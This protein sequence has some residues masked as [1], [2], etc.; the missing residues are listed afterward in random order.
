MATATGFPQARAP[1]EIINRHLNNFFRTPEELP[2]TWPFQLKLLVQQYNLTHHESLG[3]SPAALL[4]GRQTPQQTG[5]TVDLLKDNEQHVMETNEIRRRADQRMKQLQSELDEKMAHINFN[6]VVGMMACA[7]IFPHAK[8]D[9]QFSEPILIVGV[10]Y[11]RNEVLLQQGNQ[12][13]RRNFKQIR[14]LPIIDSE[15]ISNETLRETDSFHRPDA[16]TTPRIHTLDEEIPISDADLTQLPSQRTD[17]PEPVIME[18][19]Q[20]R[21]QST[22]TLDEEI[23]IS[24]ADLTQLPSERAG[25]PEPVIMEHTQN[26]KKHERLIHSPPL[27]LPKSKTKRHS[28]IILNFTSANS[29]FGGG[30]N[31]K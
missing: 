14:L 29:L 20:N 18:H 12:V 27:L 10:D 5:I 11:F 16:E 26:R 8:H 25:L 30:H 21:N 22:H 9:T 23:P 28:L 31:V 2:R 19:T 15:A 13:I 6:P 3:F 17:L 1:V 24:D 7:R 4:F